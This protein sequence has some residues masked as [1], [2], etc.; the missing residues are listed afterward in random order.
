MIVCVYVCVYTW[1]CACVGGGRSWLPDSEIYMK[2]L[3]GK[4]SQDTLDKTDQGEET[5]SAKYQ[6]LL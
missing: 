5:S 2:L 3:K 4:S 1:V 6:G